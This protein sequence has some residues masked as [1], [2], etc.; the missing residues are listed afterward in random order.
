[1]FPDGNLEAAVPEAVISYL[2]SGA[3]EVPQP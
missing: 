2:Q 1:M 3:T